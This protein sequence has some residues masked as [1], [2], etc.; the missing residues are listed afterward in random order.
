LIATAEPSKDL[1][2]LEIIKNIDKTRILEYKI[3]FDMEYIQKIEE[4]E[5]MVKENIA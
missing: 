1:E 2:S 5:R 4:I 3:V